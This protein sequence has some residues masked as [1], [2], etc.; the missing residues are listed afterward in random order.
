MRAADARPLPDRV[1]VGM[2]HS[3]PRLRRVEPLLRRCPRWLGEAALAGLAVADGFRRGRYRPGARVGRGPARRDE[4]AVARR[5]HAPCEP[6][7]VLRRGG[8]RR[9]PDDGGAC[10]RRRCGG[11]GAPP[12]AGDRRDPAGL[13]PGSAPHVVPPPDA[14]LSGPP[15]RRARHVDPGPAL[16]GPHRQRRGRLH[17]GRRDGRPPAGAL[18]D[19]RAPAP[20]G[21]GVPRRGRPLRTGGVPG[22]PA[23]R[24][25]DRAHRVAR[26]PPDDA[27]ARRSRC[28]STGTAAAG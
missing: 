4:P 6:R 26:A 8:P 12:R 18:P 27:R 24:A 9:R 23:R 25:P 10:R 7:T 14:R 3:S 21:D 2:F 19:P 16:A 5:P 17:P 1:V 15:G 22:G 28:S 13:P 20:R 11:R